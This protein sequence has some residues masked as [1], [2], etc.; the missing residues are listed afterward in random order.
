M[1]Q[2]ALIAVLL[3]VLAP[4]SPVRGQSEQGGADAEFLGLLDKTRAGEVAPE[5]AFLNAQGQQTD[6]RAYGGQVRVVN[7]WAT[8]CAPCIGE[9]PALDRLNQALFDKG[10]DG[11]VIAI[12]TDFDSKTAPLWLKENQI[13]SLE[14]FYDETGGAYFAAGGGGLPYSLIIG[15]DGRIAAEIFGDAPWDTPASVAFLRSLA[16]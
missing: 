2:V 13:Q 9:M 11:L 7:F 10:I 6:L 1:T 14:A 12:N 8:W 4:L 5:L 3:L 15:A 16:R